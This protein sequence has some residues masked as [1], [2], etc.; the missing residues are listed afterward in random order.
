VGQLSKTSKASAKASDWTELELGF[1]AAAPPDDPVEPVAA[2]TFDDLLPAEPARARRRAAAPRRQRSVTRA[3]ELRPEASG[4]RAVA[5]RIEAIARPAVTRA[6]SWTST[7]A[8]GGARHLEPLLAVPRRHLQ[9]GLVRL[10]SRIASDLPERPDGKT[11]VAAMAALLVVFGVSASVLG[12]RSNPR[13]LHF[14]EITIVAPAGG[15]SEPAE[16]PT[17]APALEPAAAPDTTARV[18]AKSAP[19][20]SSK[21]ASKPASKPLSKLTSKPA[22]KV[23]LKVS[24]GARRHEATRPAVGKPAA[25]RVVR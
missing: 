16:A 19:R 5:R 25:P 7:R 23:S 6:W 2:L 20:L 9:P 18:R 12:S 13:Q 11:I 15:P 8:A 21:P 1:F 4:L 22:S 10:W 17:A 24:S 3:P 14:P